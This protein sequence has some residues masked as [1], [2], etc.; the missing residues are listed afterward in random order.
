MPITLW[1][2]TSSGPIPCRAHLRECWP[3]ITRACLSTSLLP[4]DQ[5]IVPLVLVF[6]L[7]TDTQAKPESRRADAADASPAAAQAA[8]TQ[9]GIHGQGLLEQGL[10][11]RSWMQDFIVYKYWRGLGHDPSSSMYIEVN[12]TGSIFSLLWLDIVSILWISI[13]KSRL[14]VVSVVIVITVIAVLTFDVTLGGHEWYCL[15]RT[16]IYLC[17]S[18][19]VILYYE[20]KKAP[21]SRCQ[22]FHIWMSLSANDSALAHVQ[23]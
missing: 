21:C 23:T 15:I 12:L 16:H 19:T 6:Y 5:L 20:T 3:I 18:Y 7:L 11:V 10:W 13:E 8:Y 9:R 22:N 1:I 17:Y 14:V 2:T 4:G